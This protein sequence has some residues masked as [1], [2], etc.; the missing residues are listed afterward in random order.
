MKTRVQACKPLTLYAVHGWL[1]GDKNASNGGI[2]SKRLGQQSLPV[3]G[4]QYYTTK[5]KGSFQD[6]DTMKVTGK[7][8]TTSQNCYTFKIQRWRARIS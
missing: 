1:I 8:E 6:D 5:F 3:S 7:D 2:R 4:W